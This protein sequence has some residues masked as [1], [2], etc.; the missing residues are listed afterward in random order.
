MADNLTAQQRSANMRAVHGKDTGPELVIRSMLHRLGYRF[1][2]HRRDLPGTPD[3]VL[4]ARRCVIFV[5]GCFWH[6]HACGRGQLPVTNAAFWKDKIRENRE[7]DKRVRRELRKLGWRVLLVWQCQT[8][9]LEPLRRRTIRFL[10]AGDRKRGRSD[11][12][13]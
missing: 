6:G 7:R 3:I 10:D 13:E 9:D 12:F 2:L 11:S 8:K 4:P 5:N 1:R